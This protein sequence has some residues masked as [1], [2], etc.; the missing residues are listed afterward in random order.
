M[1]PHPS[2]SGGQHGRSVRRTAAPERDRARGS[3]NTTR[4]RW[5]RIDARQTVEAQR[6]LRMIRVDEHHVT[7]LTSAR[8]RLGERDVPVHTRPPL[9]PGDARQSE[10]ATGSPLGGP[11]AWQRVWMCAE[12]VDQMELG[13]AR[14]SQQ[15]PSPMSPHIRRSPHVVHRDGLEQPSR[16]VDASCARISPSPTASAAQAHVVTQAWASDDAGLREDGHR[17]RTYALPRSNR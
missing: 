15:A 10:T 14:A 3:W 7:G 1:Q 2:G 11:I 6:R 12:W 13:A 8:R 5:A 9:R 4:H 16:P 17:E